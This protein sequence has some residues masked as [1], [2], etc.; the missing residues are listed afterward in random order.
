MMTVRVERVKLVPFS[1]DGAF[2]SV[3]M[4]RHSRH[5]LDRFVNTENTL[6]ASKM[7]SEFRE[8]VKEVLPNLPSKYHPVIMNSP[9]DETAA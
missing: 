8:K 5:P 1:E 4:K 3:E 9:G 7:L 6:S 2:Y